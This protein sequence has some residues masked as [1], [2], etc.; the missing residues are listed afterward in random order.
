MEQ[1]FL[2]NVLTLTRTDDPHVGRRYCIFVGQRVFHGSERLARLLECLSRESSIDGIT[3]RLSEGGDIFTVEQVRTV[4]KTQLIPAGLVST[5]K[6]AESTARG[7][8]P[9]LFFTR[10]LV[11]PAAVTRAC[12]P[13]TF[14]FAPRVLALALLACGGLLGGWMVATLSHSGSLRAAVADFDMTLGDS[15]LLY[16][17][18]FSAFAFHELGHAAASRYSGADPAEI[19]IG[20]YLLFP[21][22]FCNVT[23]AWRL[24][25]ASRVRVNLGGAYFQLLLTAL[26]APVQLVTHSTPIAVF[27][28]ASATSMLVTLNPF[29]RFDGYWVY[30][31]LFRLPNLRDQARTWGADVLARVTRAVAGRRGPAAPPSVDAP[32]ALRVYAVASTLF[33]TGFGLFAAST[34]WRLVV[35]LPAL[36]GGI[37]AKFEHTPPLEAIVDVYGNAA[38][39]VAYLV[40]AL[41]SAMVALSTLGRGARVVRLALSASRQPTSGSQGASA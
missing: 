1:Y 21:V 30:S 32:M 37:R 25:R 15:L 28:G 34:T 41:L 23:E 33:F 16:T 8:S 2:T 11:G 36:L 17:L 31:D 12:S 24:P 26:A 9:Y 19:G 39:V 29:F 20:L 7:L 18:L 38:L 22:L 14:L 13:F 3:A 35:S 40:G 10:R 27:I 5:E 4:I 6:H